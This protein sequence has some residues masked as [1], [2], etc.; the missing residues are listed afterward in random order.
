MVDSCS[1]INV[2]QVSRREI[3][4]VKVYLLYTADHPRIATVRFWGW[5]EN[6]REIKLAKEDPVQWDN[7]PSQLDPYMQG[8]AHRNSIWSQTRLSEYSII[9]ADRRTFAD[10]LSPVRRYQ[11]FS[12]GLIS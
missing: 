12:H 7:L 1:H 8:V 4:T 6:E 3:L 11:V 10:L 9:K 5:A 2:V